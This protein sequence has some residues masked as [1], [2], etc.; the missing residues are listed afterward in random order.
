MKD[1]EKVVWANELLSSG[2]I[3]LKQKKRVLSSRL[4]EVRYYL[5]VLEDAG[6]WWQAKRLRNHLHKFYQSLQPKADTLS[7]EREEVSS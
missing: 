3:A 2:V 1:R 6:F 5:E 7:Q 4:I